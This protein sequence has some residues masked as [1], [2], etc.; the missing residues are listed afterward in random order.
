[1]QQIHLSRMAQVFKLNYKVAFSFSI[2]A[3]IRGENKFVR[4]F[5][6]F[7]SKFT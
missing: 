1:M 2:T 6:G 5:I 4:K 7:E 3:N